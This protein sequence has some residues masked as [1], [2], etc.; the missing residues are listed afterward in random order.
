MD[1]GVPF[2]EKGRRDVTDMFKPKVVTTV[3]GSV[4]DK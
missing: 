3:A 4:Q 1:K 2:L